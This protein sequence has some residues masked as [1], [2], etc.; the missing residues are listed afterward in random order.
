MKTPIK[1]KF[2]IQFVFKTFQTEHNTHVQYL[3]STQQQKIVA[4]P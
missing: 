4:K 3:G 2:Q 1:F